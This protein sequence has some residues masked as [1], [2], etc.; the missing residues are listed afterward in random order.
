MCSAFTKRSPNDGTPTGEGATE[1][2]VG[3]KCVINYSGNLV[4]HSAFICIVNL[5]II[6][7]SVLI[8]S[9]FRAI[10]MFLC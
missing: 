10:L 6:V 8:W 2:K 1:D 3:L 4:F 7:F 9:V 5:S